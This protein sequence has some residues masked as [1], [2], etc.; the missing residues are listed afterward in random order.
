M[1]YMIKRLYKQDV[2]T[3]DLIAAAAEIFRAYGLDAT[4]EKTKPKIGGTEVDALLHIQKGA[5]ETLFLVEAKR[6]P[7]EITLAQLMQRRAHEH[8]ALLVADYVPPRLADRLRAARIPFVDAAGNAWVETPDFLIWVAGQKP[9]RDLEAPKPA[10][11]F[12][13]AGLQLIFAV[14]MNPDWVALPTREL[15]G[16]LGLANGTV[17]AALR[18]L[19][20]Q[21]FVIQLGKRGQRR[22]RNRTTLLN[23]W[24]EGY[25]QRL[26]PLTHVNRFRTART[27][28]DWWKGLDFVRHHAL[29]GGEP[30]AAL[31]TGFLMPDVITIYIEQNHAPL[32]VDLGLRPDPDGN[33]VLRRRFWKFR[34]ETWEA[35]HVTPPLLVYADLMGAHDARC[36]ET[37]GRIKDQYL[38]RFLED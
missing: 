30:A 32:V 25:V 26:Q 6:T 34:D 11:A 21:G 5:H 12:A 19:Q 20:E 10:R 14:L 31:L 22:L 37:A 18:D 7:N 3:R 35:K 24:T 27:E 13:G 1:S 36:I 16:R 8:G 33:V 23:K 9:Q 15:A 2:N 17:A 4:I 28:K 29:L 38:A